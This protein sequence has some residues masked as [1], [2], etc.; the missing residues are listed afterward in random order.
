MIDRLDRGGD[1]RADDLRE[2]ERRA[3]HRR[4]RGTARSTLRSRSCD[5]RHPAPGRAEEGVHDHD[6]RREER[7]VGGRPEAAEVGDV[8]EQLPVEESQTSGWIRS[9][10]IQIGSRIRLRAWRPTMNHVSRSE[11]TC[12][13]RR[14]G[15][16]REVAAG[17][18]E[19]DV[20]ERG[21]VRRH[22]LDGDPVR[23]ERRRGSPG[24]ARA[25][26]STRVRSTSP[27]TV[28]SCTPSSS[29]DHGLGADRSPSASS[30]RA[31]PRRA[32][33]LELLG[34]ALDHDLA[35]ADDRE[36]VGE[37]VGLLEVVRGEQDRER[38]AV[39][40]RAELLPHRHARLGIEAGRRLV[41]EEHAGPVDEP[42]RDVEAPLHPARVGAREPVGGVGEADELEQLVDA[43]LEA[44]CRGGAGCGPGA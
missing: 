32:A 22:R 26:L 35:A 33:P 5:H 40:E 37:L 36:P 2:H 20:V 6:R 1:R 42:E 25:P 41:E 38:L 17:V 39:G 15:R 13:P 10:A 11:F 44:R 21:P 31:P 28:V 27:S 29:A 43:A 4:G 34:R 14:R 23:L 12:L 9:S 24:I 16:P 18:V 8:L 19:V 7:D 3:A 30:D